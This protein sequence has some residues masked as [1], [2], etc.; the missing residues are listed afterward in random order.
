MFILGDSVAAPSLRKTKVLVSSHGVLVWGRGSVAVFA[1]TRLAAFSSLC[2]QELAAAVHA[3]GFLV[4]T[5]AVLHHT[6]TLFSGMDV[7]VPKLAGRCSLSYKICGYMRL[8][9]EYGKRSWISGDQ[10]GFTGD[11]NRV[12]KKA[13]AS[14]F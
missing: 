6:N 5:E 13:R 3:A 4:H 12:H 7:P 11:K 9:F 8:C 10:F 1:R 14:F 2:T